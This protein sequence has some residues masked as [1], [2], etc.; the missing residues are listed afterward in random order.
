[1]KHPY[2]APCVTT[3]L[4]V[5]ALLIFYPTH[6]RSQ[7]RPDIVWAGG[8]HSGSINSV[9]YS[10]DGQLF[11]SGSA[12]RTIKLWRANGTFIRSLALP[13]NSNAQ[14]T[15]VPSVAFSPDDTLLGA[16]VELYHATT[17]TTY[18]ALQIWRISDGA[19]LQNFTSYG[20][21]VTSVSFSPDGQ[22]IASGSADRSV[23]VWQVANGTLVSDRFDHAEKVNAVAFS[24]DG[25]RLASAS[26]DRT[27]KL[28]RTTNWAVER[29]L[30]GHT[31]NIM[32]L[33]FSPNSATL[34]T[35]GLDETIRLWNVA[36]GGL[37][38]SL[39][40]GSDVYAVTF[41]A[42]GQTLASGGWGNTIKLWNP[43]TG[44]LNDTLFGHT[45]PVLSLSFAPDNKTLASASWYPEYAIKLWRDHKAS[46]PP[47]VTNHSSSRRIHRR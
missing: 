22:L 13:Y 6:A 41:A 45:G 9:A 30:T 28:Y 16:G 37:S 47:R 3:H 38:L 12:D 33:A 1:M 39:L 36:D 29:T 21:A 4:I 5:L 20:E 23:K 2:K 25:Q 8:G 40:H 14:I 31:D 17:Q 19:L 32:S 24:P 7:G 43:Q 10:H 11:A 18:G 35:A 44:M 27:A 42:N 26:D 34:A 15:D 46:R